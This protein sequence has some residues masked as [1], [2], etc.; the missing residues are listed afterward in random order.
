MFQH[1]L[2]AQKLCYLLEFPKSLLMTSVLSPV[3]QCHGDDSDT[4]ISRPYPGGSCKKQ[5]DST[6]RTGI[7]LNWTLPTTWRQTKAQ[8]VVQKEQTYLS[9][10]F[11]ENLLSLMSLCLFTSQLRTFLLFILCWYPLP[12]ISG[13]ISDVEQSASLV[14][15]QNKT[16]QAPWSESVS[17]LYRPS[18]SRLSAWLVPTF[19]WRIPTALFSVS[20]LEP[21][22][23]LSSNSSVVLT[24]LNGPRSRPTTSQKIW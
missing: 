11:F 4:G 3:A 23:F 9:N 7:R 13:E 18:D 12:E 24:R 16:K 20:R 19:V 15:K 1:F 8:E 5:H 14:L 2:R 17:G 6:K 10:E 22:L 21:L